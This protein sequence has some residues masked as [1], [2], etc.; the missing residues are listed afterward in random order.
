MADLVGGQVQAMFDNL[1]T[2]QPN[3]KSERVRPLGVTSKARVASLPGVPTIEEAGVAGYESYVWWG[4]FAA[5]GTPAAVVSRLQQHLAAVIQST[6]VSERLRSQ[7]ID[8]VASTPEAFE[9]F[10]NAE[11]EKWAKVVKEA[12]VK[13]E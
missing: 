4:V 6:D 1:I 12:K 10:F 2:A 3:I 5:G 11:V 9:S 7:G 13:V 8:P